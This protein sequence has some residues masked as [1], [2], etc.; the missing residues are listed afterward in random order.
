MKVNS[1]RLWKSLQ[2][3]SEH[4]AIPGGGICRETLT[5]ADRYGRDMF[6]EWCEASG[7]EVACDEL[8]NMFCTRPGTS[9]DLPALA[10]GSHLDTQ[11]TG[12]K[13]DGILGV[14]AGLEVCR[15][16]NDA[17]LATERPLT[18]VNWTNE[19]GSRFTPSMS[20]SGAYSGVFD[21]DWV[22]DQVDSDGVSVR[23]ALQS[24]GYAGGE[25]LGARKFWRHLELHIEQGPVLESEGCDVGIVIGS[26]AM[27]WNKITVM[28]KSA[29]AGT[30]PMD[31]RLDPLAAS[32]AMIDTLMREG[33]WT[34]E[35][36]VTVGMVRTTPESHSTIPTKVEFF[37]DLRHPD[38]IKLDALVALYES[39]VIDLRNKGFLVERD[40]FGSSPAQDFH[41]ETLAIM[42]R[43]AQ[44]LE[45]ASRD[46]VSGAGHDAIY[47][48][49]A[50]PSAMIFVPCEGGISHNPAERI[51]EKNAFDGTQ[52]LLETVLDLIG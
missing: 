7:L 13:Y 20:G 4:A 41:P 16:L 15:T 44:R 10:I 24:I 38:P 39:L 51:T 50:C 2:D 19:E 31:R 25:P 28:G 27:S 42:R 30:T 23:E 37:L 11:P 43:A 9:P 34:E 36:R 32:A 22:L 6:A 3:H 35:A 21:K 17:E 52:L 29:H 5:E 14:L 33:H 48:N 47:T 1:E 46:I 12:G 49:R 26:Q 18:I 8:G 45:L 40:E